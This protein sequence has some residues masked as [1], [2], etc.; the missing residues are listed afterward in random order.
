MPGTTSGIRLLSIFTFLLFASSFA[1]AQYGAS[2]EGT[3]T[4]NSGAVISGANV[5]ATDQA[6]SVSHSALTRDSGFYR[7]TWLPP[8]LYR[9][10]VEAPSFKKTSRSDIPVGS[11]AASA[12]NVIMQSGS[13][14]ETITVTSDVSSLQTENANVQGTISSI[15]VE[16]L[17]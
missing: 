9:V 6:T 17:P 7:I 2:L 11:E 13:A 8:G 3:V 1:L 4:D 12:A 14:T 5:T 15:E 10:Y 16:N